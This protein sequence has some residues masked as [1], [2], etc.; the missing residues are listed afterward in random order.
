V[1]EGSFED[2][3]D[4]CGR[5]DSNSNDKFDL[6]AFEGSTFHLLE[7][8]R[9]EELNLEIDFSSPPVSPESE[10][11]MRLHANIE[12]PPIFRESKKS[13]LLEALEQGIFGIPKQEIR[14]VRNEYI[15][16]N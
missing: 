12:S 1:S 2:F 8:H 7:Q 4:M 11:Q 9:Y 16:Q 3:K 14:C 13:A 15:T 6:A 10:S 5:L